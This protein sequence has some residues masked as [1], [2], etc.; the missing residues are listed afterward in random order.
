MSHTR[1]IQYVKISEPSCDVKQKAIE[2]LQL[3]KIQM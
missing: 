2:I 3:Y 1:K